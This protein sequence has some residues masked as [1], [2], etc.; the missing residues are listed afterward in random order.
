MGVCCEYGTGVAKDDREAVK[1]Y[2]KAAEQNHASAQFN[3]GNCYAKGLGVAKDY[4]EAYK[5][6]LLAAAQ[7]GD[8][9]RRLSTGLE[10]WMTREQI[11]EGQALARN[12]KPREVPVSGGDS[13]AASIAQ[14]RPESSG[15]GFFITE[16]GYL[17]TVLLELSGEFSLAGVRGPE[18]R[19]R[20]F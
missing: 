1:W 10:Y 7:G 4:V 16:D 3:M 19:R 12:F 2:R 20:S 6:S 15:T 8:E 13:S 17:I 14:T 9:A 18:S 5:W 11:A